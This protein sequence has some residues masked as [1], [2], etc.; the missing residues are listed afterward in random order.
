MRDDQR[1]TKGFGFVCFKSC[2]DA[3]RA[4]CENQSEQGGLYVVEALKKE[5]RDQVKNRQSLSW[6]KSLQY[7][8]LHVTG[9]LLT[10]SSLEDLTNYFRQFG[11]VRTVK[12]TQTG[13]ALVSFSDR[14]SA[15]KAKDHSNGSNFEGHILHVSFYEPKEIRNLQKQT[16]LDKRA[17]EQKRQKEFLQ[18]PLSGIDSSIYSIVN[19]LGSV[20]GIQN[21]KSYQNGGRQDYRYQ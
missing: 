5:Q 3:V 21:N 1:R 6:K 14:E 8:G 13:A 20:M 9:F 18:T 10:P 2:S 19:A 4:L 12:L 7:L 16:E 11:E 15:K 17:M